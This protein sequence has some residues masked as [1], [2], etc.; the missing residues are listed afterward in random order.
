MTNFA[1]M[2]QIFGWQETKNPYILNVLSKTPREIEVF[3]CEQT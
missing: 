3:F 1:S 2:H